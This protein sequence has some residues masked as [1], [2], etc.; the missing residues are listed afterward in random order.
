MS[1]AG[2]P[3]FGAARRVVAPGPPPANVYYP[4]F[5]PDG[6]WLLFCRAAS[7]N[8]FSNPEAEVWLVRADGLGGPVRLDAANRVGALSNSWPRWA[9]SYQQ[10]RYFVIFNSRR[11]YPPVNGGGPQQLWVSVVDV[12]RLPADPSSPAIWLPGQEAFTGNLTAE[13]SAAP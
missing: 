11:P 2:V 3:S 5:S 9:P 7:G 10:G 12:N 6:Q 4:A 8:A 1:P 13:W